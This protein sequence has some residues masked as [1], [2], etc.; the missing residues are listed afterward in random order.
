MPK[1]K[2]KRCNGLNYFLSVKIFTRHAK[3]E[4]PRQDVFSLFSYFCLFLLEKYKEKI[5][6]QRSKKLSYSNEKEKLKKFKSKKVK[7][8]FYY[9]YFV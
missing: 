7:D 1:T 4:T 8:A 9:L 2:A 5:V 3:T 6:F